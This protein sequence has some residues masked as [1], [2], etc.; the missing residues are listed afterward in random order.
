MRFG[1]LAPSQWGLDTR[2]S[3]RMGA[4]NLTERL[5]PDDPPRLDQVAK[6]D[7]W[8]RQT[9]MGHVSSPAK[10][11]M[12][13]LVGV[14]GTVVSLAAIQGGTE[15][16]KAE[17]QHGRALSRADISRQIDLFCKRS[18]KDRTRVP[19]LDP[20]RADI[21]IAGAAI[22]RA[23][24]RH[25]ETEELRISTRGLRHGVMYDRFVFPEEAWDV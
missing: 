14:G 3:V 2:L 11:G 19:G 25:F 20:R 1:R 6:L 18:S 12:F 24:M 16:S 8:I 15:G 5:L 7:E 17:A 4:V 9:L 21:I 10:A 13:S 22:L 23:V